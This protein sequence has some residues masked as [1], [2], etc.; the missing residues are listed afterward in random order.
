MFHYTRNV[1]FHYTR[2]THKIRKA[3][4]QQ[5]PITTM[6]RDDKPWHPKHWHPFYK[7]VINEIIKFELKHPEKELIMFEEPV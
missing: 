4:K 3:F 7:K 2:I 6:K 5:T 1:V